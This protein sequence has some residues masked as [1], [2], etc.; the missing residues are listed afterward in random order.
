MKIQLIFIGMLLAF[1]ACKTSKVESQITPEAQASTGVDS[2]T[3]KTDASEPT[4]EVN[5]SELIGCWLDSREENVPDSGIRVYR[6]CDYEGIPPSRFRYSITFKADGTCAWLTLS[7]NDAHFMTNGTWS[8][9]E[10]NIVTIE[11]EEGI[12]QRIIISHITE[13]IMEVLKE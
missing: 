3:Y 8:M 6:P 5:S 2:P 7:P 13:D 12:Q 1:T 4:I 10:G 11:N 9:E